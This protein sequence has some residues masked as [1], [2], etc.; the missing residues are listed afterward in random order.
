MLEKDPS[1][2]NAVKYVSTLSRSAARELEKAGYPG[3]IIKEWNSLRVNTELIDC[4][5]YHLIRGDVSY[6]HRYHNEYMKEYS[7]AEET[8]AEILHYSSR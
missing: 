3:I 6:L 8:N 7:W 1:D 5:Y 4:D 2:L